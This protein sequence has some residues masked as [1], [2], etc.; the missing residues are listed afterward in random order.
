MQQL[1]LADARTV[2]TGAGSEIFASA[3][4]RGRGDMGIAPVGRNVD[5]TRARDIS[6][7][8]PVL[9]LALAAHVVREG[10]RKLQPGGEEEEEA[11]AGL[12]V[13][14]PSACDAGQEYNNQPGGR[15][16]G[17]IA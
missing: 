2:K 5:I 1:S 3:R 9:P 12:G 17:K 10:A 6:G 15:L 13:E 14:G 16:P 11:P 7:L 8:E 4:C